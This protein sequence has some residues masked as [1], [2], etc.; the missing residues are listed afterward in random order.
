[1]NRREF[2]RGFAGTVLAASTLAPTPA[3]AAQQSASASAEL[4][5]APFHLSVMLWT[6]FRDLPFERRLEKVAEAGYRNVE[7]VG[8]Y[9]TW[10]DADFAR[11]NAKRKELGIAFDCTAGLKHGLCNPEDR[12]ALLMELRSTLPIME[13]IECPAIILLSA[14]WCQECLSKPNTRAVLMA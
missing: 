8:E 7:L 10:T 3:V 14:M 12:E 4:S 1:M 6:V 5:A 9:A 2:G 11:A 13:R